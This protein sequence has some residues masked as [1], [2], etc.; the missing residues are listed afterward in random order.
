MK[1]VILASFVLLLLPSVLSGQ[2]ATERFEKVVNRMVKAINDANWPGV[3]ADFG[4]VMLDAFPLDKLTPFFVDLTAQYGK[5]VKLDALQ[6]VPPMQATF[7]A[8]FERG[9]LDIKVV[10][11]EQDKIVGLWFLPSSSQTRPTEKSR[12]KSAL[13]I[14]DAVYGAGD[15]WINVNNQLIK[16]IHDNMVS[17]KVSNKTF[18]DPY[19]SEPKS[20]KVE[21]MLGNERHTVE[22]REGQWLHIPSDVA[23]HPELKPVKT[24]SELTALVKNCPAELGFHGKNISTGYEVEYRSDQPAC[25]ASIVKI[26][27]LLEVMRQADQ[28]ILDL[29]EPI[30]IMRGD[31]KETCTISQALDKMIGISDNEATSALAK[32]VGYDQVNALPNALGIAGLSKTIL[33]Q[34]GAL[35]KILDKRV[36]ADQTLTTELLPQHGTARGVTRYFELLSEKKLINE[37]VST[38]V[39]EV[40]DR[41]PKRWAPNATPADFKSGGKGGSIGWFRPNARPYTM[42]GWGALIRNQQTAITFCL[43]F[44]W[45]PESTS[46]DL[47]R[48]WCYTLSDSI[49]N[50]LLTQQPVETK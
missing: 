21:Y 7:P 39:L 41:N 17:V 36:Y 38:K 8:R 11:D 14:I 28:N 16:E 4:Q 5:I 3:Q 43:W 49:V 23:R 44:E 1:K 27:V 24:E 2:E 26:F 48:Q 30:T 35:D 31:N 15:T 19:P 10:L 13:Q 9:I 29:S 37:S 12:V 47:K 50:I 18:G 6:Y 25:L 45:F 20:L 42:L 22:V 34:P 32:R 46:E 40:F 33:P